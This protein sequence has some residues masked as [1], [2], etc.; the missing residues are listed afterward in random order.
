MSILACMT[1]KGTYNSTNFSFD[2]K[3]LIPLRGVHRFRAT[4]KFLALKPN[5]KQWLLL[6][7]VHGQGILEGFFGASK[8]DKLA[9]KH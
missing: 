7:T 6:Y 5:S 9:N 3:L 1:P 8:K 2:D 4:I